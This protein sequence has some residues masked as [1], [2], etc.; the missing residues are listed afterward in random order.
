MDPTFDR[1][2]DDLPFDRKKL[3]H[4]VG[5]HAQIRFVVSDTSRDK[6]TGIFSSGSLN[7][8]ARLSPAA[9]PDPS[10]PTECAPQCGFIPGMSLKFLRSGIA[11]ANIVAMY[12]LAGQPS[13]NFFLNNFTN[14]PYLACDDIYGSLKLLYNKF[15]TASEWPTTVGLSTLAHYDEAGNVYDPPRFP[16]QLWFVPNASLTAQFPDFPPNYN[17]GTLAKQ[18]EA[19]PAGTPLYTVYGLENPWD[20]AEFLGTIETTTAFTTSKWGDK[21]MFIQHTRM[22]EDVEFHPEWKSYLPTC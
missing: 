14:H 5:N 15:R 13:F 12:S 17:D 3:I 6:Y 2:A 8:I 9:E 21:D 22:E 4:S 7:G 19:I 18:L 16:Y 11:S 20:P 10:N 1:V